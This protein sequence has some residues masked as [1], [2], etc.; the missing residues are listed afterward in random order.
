MKIAASIRD[1]ILVYRESMDRLNKSSIAVMGEL[2]P[3]HVVR[4]G[5]ELE[6]WEPKV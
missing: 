1:K 2:K 4:P 5:I 3:Q 6:H